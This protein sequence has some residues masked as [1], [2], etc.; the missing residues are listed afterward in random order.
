MKIFAKLGTY[1]IFIAMAIVIIF[2][3]LVTFLNSLNPANTISTER[4]IPKNAG[5]SNY[6]ELFTSDHYEYPLWF[7]N[8]FLLSVAVMVVSTTIIVSVGYMYS[9]YRFV[10]RRFG[11]IL[12]LIVQVLPA[13]A[14]LIAFYAMGN[15]VGIYDNDSAFLQLFYLFLIYVNGALPV[16]ILLMRGY[17]DSISKELD[18]SARIDGASPFRIFLEIIVP[19]AKP[20][21]VV[22]AFFGFM[23][24]VQDYIMPS[25]LVTNSKATTLMVGL[26]SMVSDPKELNE[27]LF[28]SGAI[29]M[30][31]PILIVFFLLQKHIVGGLSAGGVKG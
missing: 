23:A 25:I 7:A 28:A 1:L 19:I 11:L 31:V 3:V 26:D 4:L 29:L 5:F 22:V 16:N 2:P 8:T 10:G 6:I 30:A 13:G 14:A 18:E 9:R 17:F 21:I 12:L 24:P 27:N 20:M 15:A